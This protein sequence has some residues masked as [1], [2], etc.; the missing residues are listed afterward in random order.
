MRNPG[1]LGHKAVVA[2]NPFL[3]LLIRGALTDR[4]LLG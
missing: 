2:Q 4:L 3:D 1:T